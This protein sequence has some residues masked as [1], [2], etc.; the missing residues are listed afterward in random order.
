[1]T[2]ILVGATKWM[3]FRCHVWAKCQSNKKCIEKN[4]SNEELTNE[5]VSQEMGITETTKKIGKRKFRQYGHLKRIPRLK[6]NDGK[7]MDPPG[8]MLLRRW[9]LEIEEQMAARDLRPGDWQDWELWRSTVWTT[10]GIR[11]CNVL[12]GSAASDAELWIFIELLYS[13]A[14][15]TQ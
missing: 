3:F 4:L 13:L 7:K 15:P 1:M 2:S 14:K 10:I 9:E 6:V 11:S 12:T 5:D 8:R